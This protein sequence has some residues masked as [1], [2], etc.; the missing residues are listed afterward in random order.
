MAEKCKQCNNFY[1][2]TT[3]KPIIT[4]ECGCIHCLECI[5]TLMNENSQRKILCPRCEEIRTLPEELKASIEIMKDL[6]SQDSLQITCDE[7][8]SKIT[9]QY[10]LMCDIPICSACELSIHK[11]HQ[12][13][14]L[15]QS[16]FISYTENVKSMLD[17]YSSQ[18]VKFKLDQYAN[19]EVQLTSSQFKSMISKVSRILGHLVDDEERKSIYFPTCLGIPQNDPQSMKKVNF[20]GQIIA[21]ENR[22]STEISHRDIKHLI[23]ESQAV[24]REEFKQAL[25]A[26]EN[27]SLQKQKILTDSIDQRISNIQQDISNQLYQFK[28]QTQDDLEI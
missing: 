24:L 4:N 27:T 13:I 6:R 22:F 25:E 19:N 5:T 11:D 1:N 15:K 7:H 9:T 12:L 17:E 8:Q 28:Q 14:N 26:F 10:C 2:L 21:Q 20:S 18:T 3:R 16:K 23:N